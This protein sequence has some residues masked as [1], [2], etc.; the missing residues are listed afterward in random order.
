M[1]TAVLN[2]PGSRVDLVELDD[3]LRRLEELDARKSQVVEMRVFG[4]L[5]VEEVA[6]ILKVSEITIIR[7][8]QLALSWLR[9][10]LKS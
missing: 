8:W 7:D 5:T 4:G 9:R 3:A 6:V 1:N 10:E 2:T